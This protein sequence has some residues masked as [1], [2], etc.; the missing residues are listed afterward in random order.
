MT[1]YRVMGSVLHNFLCT[2]TSRY[3]DYRGYWLL[4]QLPWSD[5]RQGTFDLLGLAP[6][7]DGPAEA[8]RRLAIH[9][10]AEQVRKSGLTLSAVREAT[11][12]IA[13]AQ[14]VIRGW[15]GDQRADGHMV[16]FSAQSVMENGRVYQDDRTMFVAP[17][18]PK[19]ERRRHAA[20]WGT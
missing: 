2:Y 20:D 12:Q 4:G 16:R 3:S 11:L 9:R 15:Q 18:D 17:H 14:E 13:R 10:F 8:A 1:T 5:L 7:G 6:E 19:K